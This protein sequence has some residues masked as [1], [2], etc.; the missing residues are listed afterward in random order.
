[1]IKDAKVIKSTQEQATASWIGYLNQLRVNELIIGLKNQDINLKNAIVELQELKN[2]VGDPSHILGSAMTKFGEI[3][4]HAQV[5]ISNARNLI[6]GLKP[7]YTFEGIGRFDAVDYMFNNLPIQSKFNVGIEGTINA[8]KGHMAKYPYFLSNGGKYDIPKD[9]YEEIMSI[10]SKKPSMLNRHEYTL[11][12]TIRE[13]EK[14]KG[15][16]F[17]ENVNPSIMNYKEIQQNA[18]NG[19]I[20]SEESSIREKDSEIRD[21]YVEDSKAT[22]REGAK[23]AAAGA[24]LEGGMAF[25]L[26]VI[27]KHKEGK[28]LS[29]FTADDWKDVGA[30][31]GTGAL[32]GGI[33]G[34][35]VY[36]MTNF[37]A[38]SAPVASAFA[39]AAFGVV[40]QAKMLHDGKIDS[41]EFIVNSE[42][43]CLDVAV[44]AVSSIFGQ[45]IIPVPVLGALAGNAA[46]MLA[47]GIVKNHLSGSEQVYVENYRLSLKIL[48]QEL[49]IKCKELVETLRSEL[50]NFKSIVCTA[51]DSDISSAFTGS[52]KLAR[53]VGITQDMI[54]MGKTEID[55]YF[56]A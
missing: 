39:T 56:L 6:Q 24:V 3:A 25:C 5:N 21:K 2:F 51:F 35:G 41:E 15:I 52:V 9:R 20:K 42:A 53:Y 48:E 50:E 31:T 54:L 44:S 37:T 43:V 36:V 45:F 1:M 13:M 38:T 8:I 26:K 11:F 29:Q 55:N 17:G 7:L 34:A 18:I 14:F 28:K 16:K 23:A 46:G 4:E 10:L 49:D 30:D 12:K 22:L 33:R 47:Y 27:K 19:T 40:S 32:K